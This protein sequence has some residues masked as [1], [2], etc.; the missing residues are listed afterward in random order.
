MFA[1]FLAISLPLY[2]AYERI[3]ETVAFESLFKKNRFLI[4]GKYIMV[5]NA[6]LSH[7]DDRKVIT[8]DIL[9]RDAIDRKDLIELKRKINL[10]F[11]DKL[12]IKIQ[13]HH[14]L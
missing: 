9:T 10:H 3:V 12:M 5:Q 11:N 8:A 4:N 13:V 1:L 2:A 14:V 6:Y 7:S